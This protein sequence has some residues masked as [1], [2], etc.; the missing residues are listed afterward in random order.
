M[1]LKSKR[2]LIL[3]TLALML[4]LSQAFYAQ[5]NLENVQ[6]KLAEISQILNKAT[7]EGDYETLIN[8]HTDD[9]IVKPDFVPAIKGKRALREQY[10]KNKKAGAK[11]HSFS[12]TTEDM[13]IRGD[14]VYE[15]GTF[16][17]AASSKE[18]AKPVAVY[19]SYFQIWLRQADGA[20]KIKYLI[21]NLDF[22]PYKGNSEN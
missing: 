20:Y 14:E 15:R 12:A 7:L 16:G 1:Q 17:M 19:G 11:I 4:L 18:S 13:W 8:C 10:E 22:D 5:D 2:V 6:K 21:W 9:A 3:L